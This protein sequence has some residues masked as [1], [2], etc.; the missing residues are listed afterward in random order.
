MASG[1]GHSDILNWFTIVPE[2]VA[3]IWSSLGLQDS[4]DLAFFWT[5]AQGV[6]D[7]LP[8]YDE[9]KHELAV[10]VWRDARATASTVTHCRAQQILVSQR[11]KRS[12][13][14]VPEAGV[15]PSK[16]HHGPSR[17]RPRRCRSSCHPR[18]APPQRPRRDWT[19]QSWQ[20]CGPSSVHICVMGPLGEKWREVT[21]DAELAEL[22]I[23]VLQPILPQL[24]YV[25][26]KLSQLQRWGDW[27]ARAG[28]AGLV[29]RPTDLALGKL[30]REVATGGPTAAQGM[31]NALDWL[32]RYIGLPSPLDSELLQQYRLHQGPPRAP[33]QAVMLA[34]SAIIS[35]V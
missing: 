24:E 14:D 19:H 16:H 1:S 31:F 29:W 28:A 7:A 34:V 18:E 13:L 15:P 23:Q 20:T 25:P 10:A 21:D 8:Q 5:T 4:T 9:H 2:P 3:T 27:H 6:V 17:S 35:I 26:R 12:L 33:Q 22:R 32:R 30:F 11:P